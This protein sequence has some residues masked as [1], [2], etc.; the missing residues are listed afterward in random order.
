MAFSIFLAAVVVLVCV[1]LNRFTHRFGIPVLLAFIL[2]GMAFGTDGIL[3]IPFENYEFAERICSVALIFIMFYGGFGTNWK[4][5]R[6]VAVQAG[7]LSTLGVALTSLLVGGFCY[8]ALRIPFPES[9]LIGAVVGST[10]A[11]SVFSILR[12]KK[13]GL[14][15]NT[16]SMLELESGSNDPMSYMLTVILLSFMGEGGADTASIL[17]LIFS[18]FALGIAFGVL[19]GFVAA[20]IMQRVRF[21]ADGFDMAFVVGV[22]L[23]AYGTASVTG[24]NGYLAAYLSGIILGNRKIRNQKA[25]VNFFDGV[26]GL[27]QMLIFFL[28]GLLATPSLIPRIFLPS[29]LIM[30]ALTFLARPLA[31]FLI[32]TPFRCSVRQQALVSFAGLRGAA[33]IVFAIMATVSPPYLEN[34]LFHMVFCIV[35]LSITFQGTLLPLCAKRLGMTDQGIDV[36]KTFSD[37]SEEI[38][39]RFIQIRIREQHPWAEQEIRSVTLPPDTLIVLLLREGMRLVPDGKTVLH[40][41]DV[42]VLSAYRYM[43]GDA[44]G[45]REYEV[46]HG[47]EWIGKTIKQ[48]SPEP[49]ELVIMLL[50]NGRTILPKGNTQIE[51][52][53]MLVILS[54]DEDVPKVKAVSENG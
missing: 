14:K 24:G 42:A 39:L 17:R 25:L 29:L 47:S 50:R 40:A 6:P 28:L 26:T 43:S 20:F 19:T 11:A 36:L 37:Y 35:L 31:V 12:S 1:L 51:K 18:Q 38:E 44:I 41:G 3:K 15:D 8:L 48:F 10:D 22:A 53:D 23:L 4:Q 7:L 13:L 5:A 34:D 30:L 32:L 52:N 16:D 9:L 49:G 45:L 46:Q 54:S 2:L 33:S 21:M 27:M